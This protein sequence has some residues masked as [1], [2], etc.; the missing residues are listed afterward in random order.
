MELQE[1]VGLTITHVKVNE[2]KTAISFVYFNGEKSYR[3]EGDCC[4]YSWIEHLSG[5]E[6]L[7]GATVTRIEDIALPEVE[8]V[9]GWD[10]VQSYGLKIHT[11]KG[12]ALLEYRNS[13]NGYYGGYLSPYESDQTL[14]LFVIED[15]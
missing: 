4:S 7:I 1:L 2:D 11:N 5:I 10:V 15:F 14:P 12:Y 8:G 6:Q 13:S 9:D 3:A